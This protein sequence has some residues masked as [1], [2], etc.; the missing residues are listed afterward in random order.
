MGRFGLGLGILFAIVI[1]LPVVWQMTPT[2]TTIVI[3]TTAASSI[4][5]YLVPAVIVVGGLAAIFVVWFKPFEKFG[6]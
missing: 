3:G 1:L 2:I 6:G 4:F 5:T